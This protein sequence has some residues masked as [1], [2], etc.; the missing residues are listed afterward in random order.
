MPKKKIYQ[1]AKR[2]M[3]M[4]GGG[5]LIEHVKCVNSANFSWLIHMVDPWL[6]IW[7]MLTLETFLDGYMWWVPDWTYQVYY[8]ESFS[9]WIHVMGPWLNIWSM[10]TLE[11]F[12]AGYMWWVPECINSG[13]FSWWIRVGTVC[14]SDT[15]WQ[16]RYLNRMT[17]QTSAA[18]YN[19]PESCNQK[20]K[21]VMNIM[22]VCVRDF[23]KK[24]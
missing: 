1:T 14:S 15:Q 11:T 13:N 9:W 2:C 6:S 5:S 7:S 4:I 23:R 12:L 18:A 10:L 20:G 16:S 21:H 22:T 19:Y 17:R 8:S 24:H 3:N